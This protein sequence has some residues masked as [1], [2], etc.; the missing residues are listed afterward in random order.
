MHIFYNMV[1]IIYKRKNLNLYK[2]FLLIKYINANY[3]KKYDLTII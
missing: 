2:I 1:F 3:Y